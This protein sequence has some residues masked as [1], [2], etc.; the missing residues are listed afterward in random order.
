MK[1]STTALEKFGL[2]SDEAQIYVAVLSLENPGVSGIAKKVRKQR[3]AT[4]FHIRKMVD[5]GFLKETMVGR[6]LHF[7]ATPPNELARLFDHW[8]TD[9]KS[10]VPQLEALK[11]IEKE[12]PIIEVKESKQGYFDIYD[13][14]SS[15][16]EGSS[17]RVVEGQ[18]ALEE[19]LTLLSDEQWHTF[20]TRIVDR[21]IKTIGLF[22]E[23]ALAIPGRKLS[24]K[25]KELLGKREWELR[26]L[27]ED[28]FPM[29]KLFFI[30]GDKIAFLFPE[31]SLVVTIKHKGIAQ[32][33]T[34]MF[35]GIFQFGKPIA[36][37]WSE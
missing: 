10:L 16:P 32:I 28:K 7:I 24:E 19:E 4:Y 37:A 34:A 23:E 13:E 31:S 3:T 27:T 22:T 17:F 14:I 11:V 12:I 1:Q 30:Y 6:S 26:T 2:S 25:N 15:M 18:E 5:K 9:F 33:M 21:S 8:T 20:F 36:S 35:D 29:Q